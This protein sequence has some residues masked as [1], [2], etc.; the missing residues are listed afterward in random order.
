MSDTFIIENVGNLEKHKWEHKID[1]KP[2]LSGVA[3]INLCILKE[4]VYSV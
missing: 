4:T 2:H 1:P 3:I